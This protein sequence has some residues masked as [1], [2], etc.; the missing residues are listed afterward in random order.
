VDGS[1]EDDNLKIFV[2]MFSKDTI[3]TGIG[4][5]ADSYDLFVIG[6]VIVLLKDIYNPTTLQISLIAGASLA[7]AI[8]G[9]LMKA[10][11]MLRE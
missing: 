7:S 4:F 11:E 1:E 8:I 10:R 3:I 2:K 5:A 9:Q 6:L